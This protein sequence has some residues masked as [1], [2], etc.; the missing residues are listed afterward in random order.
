MRFYF[1]LVPVLL[2]LSACATKPPKPEPASCAGTTFTLAHESGLPP[3]GQ[4]NGGKPT[5]IGGTPVNPADWPEVVRSQAGNAGCS[6][7]IVGPRVLAIAAHCVPNGGTL[8]FNALANRYT[9]RCSHHPEYRGNSTADFALCF[10]D[11]EVTGVP[12]AS[13]ATENPF[14][15]GDMA[16]LM[17]YG[18]T[19][20]GGTGGNDGILRTGRSRV[21]QLPSGNSYDTVTVGEAALCYGDSGGPFWFETETG[22]RSLVGVNSRGNISTTSYLSSW[23]VPKALAWLKGWADQNSARICGVHADAKGCRGAK[24]PEPPPSPL[25]KFRVDG[26]AA[27][28]EGTLKS[29]FEGKKEEIRGKVQEALE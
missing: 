24:P 5:L 10:T 23:W 3:K 16:R 28:V 11:R 9:A 12:F 20:P 2:L 25:V 18:C 21:T 26:N 17:G 22:D 13:I 14:K 27:C 7:T 19:R 29:G 4:E 6:S 15:I 8:T 1:G